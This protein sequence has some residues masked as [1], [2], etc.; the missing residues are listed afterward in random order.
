MIQIF[1]VEQGTAEWHALRCG[2]PTAS[3]FSHIMAQGEGKMRRKYLVQLAGEII[4]GEPAREFKNEMME[5]G[6][7]LQ[8]EA[9]SAYALLTD[10]SPEIVGFV[11]NGRI[12]CSPDALVG[13][14][15]AAE[16]KCHEPHI[17]VER[18]LG[19]APSDPI[20]QMQGQLMV[21]ERKW[22]DHVAYCPGMPV[23]RKR[24]V[25]D[26]SFIARMRVGIDAFLEDLDEVVAKVRNYGRV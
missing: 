15:G 10:A 18:L 4:T 19:N 9:M 24:F 17:M 5:R 16:V 7:A 23:Y 22:I 14:D 20:A 12:G 2:I 26:E 13:Q 6:T 11:K 25:R 3:K 21:L 1:D 8:G